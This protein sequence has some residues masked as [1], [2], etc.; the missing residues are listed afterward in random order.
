MGDTPA[1]ATKI[2]LIHFGKIRNR[3]YVDGV[4]IAVKLTG[5]LLVHALLDIA[6]SIAQ[7]E[8]QLGDD[9]D[10]GISKPGIF[11]QRS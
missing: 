6:V 5:D 4:G 9:V 1:N 8:I 7:R 3:V 11:V 10:R 2:G